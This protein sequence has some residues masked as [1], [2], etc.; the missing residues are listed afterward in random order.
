MT[1][2]MTLQDISA[3]ETDQQPF[4]VRERPSPSDETDATAHR[5][6]DSSSEAEKRFREN[7][8]GKNAFL[9]PWGAWRGL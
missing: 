3:G 6:P 5:L 9:G 1:R 7:W 4:T 2:H 8:P